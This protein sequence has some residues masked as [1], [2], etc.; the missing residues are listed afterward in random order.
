MNLPANPN[1]DDAVRVRYRIRFAKVDLLRWISHRDLAMLWDRLGRRV[2]LHFSM[3]EGF[4]PKPRI[5]FPSALALGIESDNEV[6]ELDL[7]S[8][9]SPD[10]LLQRLVSDQQ[11]GLHFRRVERLPDL[12]SKARVATMQYRIDPPT[13]VSRDE[14]DAGIKRVMTTESITLHRKKKDTAVRPSDQIETFERRG[15]HLHGDDLHGDYLHLVMHDVAGAVMKPDEVLAAMPIDD[16]LARGG[17]IRRTDVR[18]ANPYTG[19][20]VA[21]VEIPSP[22]PSPRHHRVST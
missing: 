19:D 14:L 3:T 9:I 20:D 11:P 4:H 7:A 12:T 22:F 15:D 18:L 8:E 10:E 17:R 16:F 1:A 5:N 2:G 21:E 13:D 6:V